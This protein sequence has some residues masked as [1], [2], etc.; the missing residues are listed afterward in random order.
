VLDKCK[1]HRKSIHRQI[2][3]SVAYKYQ[4]I[5]NIFEQTLWNKWALY[6]LHL[7][8]ERVNLWP[9]CLNSMKQ[10][11]IVLGE[12]WWR[13]CSDLCTCVTLQSLKN[14]KCMLTNNNYL[15]VVKIMPLTPPNVDSATHSGIIHA[16]KPYMRCANVCNEYSWLR[17]LLSSQTPATLHLQPWKFSTGCCSKKNYRS[18]TE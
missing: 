11:L 2:I 17:T 12:R 4:T 6:K 1:H 9:M 15:A 13:Q 16:M 8:W 7:R 18:A 10:L 5:N 14:S 3:T